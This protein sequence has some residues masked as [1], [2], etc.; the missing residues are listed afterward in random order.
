MEDCS[1]KRLITMVMGLFATYVFCVTPG[2]ALEE[3][4]QPG[5]RFHRKAQIQE[6]KMLKAI[7]WAK[8]ITQ[9]VNAGYPEVFVSLYIEKSEAG[10]IVH[11]F[12][13]YKDSSTYEQV[14]QRIRRDE[15]Y[16]A[17]I[18]QS[19]EQNLFI[20]ESV[21]N[22]LLASVAALEQEKPVVD[23]SK[24]Q[25]GK[26]FFSSENLGTF[27]KILAGEGES[28]P[29]TISGT[30]KIPKQVTGKVPAVI[31]L[32]G[33][34][35][36][37]GHYFEAAE[38]LNE[39][40]IASFVVD[41]FT[42]RGMSGL[43]LVKK[44][45]FHSYAIRVSDAYAAL[46]LLS[47]HPKIDRNKIAVM[48]YSHG[49]AVA[50]FVA[51]EKI[52]RS[53]IVDG[54]RFAASIAYYPPCGTQLENID[55]TDAPVLMLLAEKDN[56][57]PLEGSLI[58]AKRIKESGADVKVVVYKGAHH[59]FPVVP[60]DKTINVPELPDWSHCGKEELLYL[61]DDGSWFFPHTKKTVDEVNGIDGDYTADCR[62]DGGAIVGGNEKA[63]L[64]SIKEY[65]NLLRKVFNID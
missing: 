39:M 48:G 5:I 34:G 7:Q 44:G 58:Y 46:D 24:G 27:K 21:H 33:V 38:M 47:T 55:F 65:Q 45:T 49:A 40:G 41:S 53:F 4:K 64:E 42:P 19:S 20:R 60:G 18:S 56:M 17:L 52:R 9:Y 43:D 51:S 62:I 35:G 63:K 16:L 31:I 57:C 59:Q 54:L 8:E 61:R 30:L 13:D 50:L 14:M 1:R 12:V 29:V 15:K 22:T 28:K 37:N 6:N 11:W 25:E 2:I 26:I 3:K 36:V 23:L 32:H 10:T